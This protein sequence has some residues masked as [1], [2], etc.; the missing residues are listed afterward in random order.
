MLTCFGISHK[1]VS[2]YQ[3]KLSTSTVEP[4][5]KSVEHRKDTVNIW[6]YIRLVPKPGLI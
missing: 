6:V 3:L 5:T 4:T 2:I 1:L